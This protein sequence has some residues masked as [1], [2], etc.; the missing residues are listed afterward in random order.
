MNDT[1][2]VG[3]GHNNPPVIDDSTLVRVQELVDAANLWLSSVKEIADP[4]TARACDDFLNQLKAELRALEEDRQAKVRPYL[5]GQKAVNTA[6]ERPK[7]LLDKA[8]RL[9]NPLKTAWLKREAD[10]IAAAKR[11]AEEEALRKMQ[12][13]E[14]LKRREPTSIEAAVAADEARKKADEAVARAHQISQRKAQVKGDYATRSSSLRSYW[15]AEI[16]D[17]PKALQH[18]A[19]HPDIRAAVERLANADARA[20]KDALD[21]PGLRPVEEKRAA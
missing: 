2:T 13:A 17:Y 14:D 6:F 1:T 21:V 3:P 18:Y 16:V 10:R 20:M 4:D 7:A 9:L 5:D 15:S 19:S 12:E 11:E 8:I